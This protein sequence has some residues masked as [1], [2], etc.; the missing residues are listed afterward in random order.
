MDYFP[1][2]IHPNNL[3]T[4]PHLDD[5]LTALDVC[6]S[7]GIDSF[8]VI[9][10]DDAA[11]KA[12]YTKSFSL[13][14]VVSNIKTYLERNH[15]TQESFILDMKSAGRR[16]IQVDEANAEVMKLLE[17]VSFMTVE[18]SPNNGQVWLALLRWFNYS[19]HDALARISG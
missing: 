16:I 10:K 1:P 13:R 15:R 6:S 12:T 2:V 7:V 14:D 18:T 5:A 9:F 3:L 8:N 19:R 4:E 11:N 17:D